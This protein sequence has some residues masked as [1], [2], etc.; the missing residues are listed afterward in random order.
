MH[1]YDDGDY[2]DDDDVNLHTGDPVIVSREEVEYNKV[3]P[4]SH[5]FVIILMLVI[6]IIISIMRKSNTTRLF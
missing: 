2:G 1:T 6:I 3:T 5:L 4:F